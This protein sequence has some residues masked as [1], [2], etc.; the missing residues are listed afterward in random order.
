MQPY[1]EPDDQAKVA[2]LAASMERVGWI[3]A[4]LVAW[5]NAFLTGAHRVA[6]ARSLDWTDAHIPTVAIEDVFAEAGLDFDAVR[7]EEGCDG[8]DSALLPYVLAA[9]PASIR[10]A[11]GIDIH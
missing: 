7:V 9:L 4:P 11:Y 6:A 10:E 5:G 1:H 2:T 8:V 3:G